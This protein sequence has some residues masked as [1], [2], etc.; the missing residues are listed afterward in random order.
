M[1]NTTNSNRKPENEIGRIE[2]I[3]H[4]EWLLIGLFLFHALI[5]RPISILDFIFFIFGAQFPDILEAILFKFDV[6]PSLRRLFTHTF[7]FPILLAFLF[8]I[9][10][11][12]DVAYYLFTVA[13]FGHLILDLFAGGD[14]VYFLSPITSKLKLIIINKEKRL[15]IG[16]V[17]Y[18]KLGY[19]WENG[20]NGD[21]AW[22]WILQFFGSVIAGVSFCIYLLSLHG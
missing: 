18:Q 7:L 10:F 6:K 21:L 3:K 12:N 19:L 1:I 17:V 4:I 11:K 2:A 20:T 13:Y 22:F 15:K 14:P 9:Y 16:N 8:F 5:K